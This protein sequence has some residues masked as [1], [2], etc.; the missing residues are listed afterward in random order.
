L[1]IIRK[2]IEEMLAA[3]NQGEAKGLKCP[4]CWVV[5]FSVKGFQGV[6]NTVRLDGEIRR[7]RTC[8]NCGHVWVTH[9]S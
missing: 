7:Y 8:R 4:R 3:A 9:E 2:P 1:K 5:Q 6:R